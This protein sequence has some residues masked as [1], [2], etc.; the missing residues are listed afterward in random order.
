[1][2]LHKMSL[3]NAGYQELKPCDGYPVK[4]T[5][6]VVRPST[7]NQ[8]HVQLIMHVIASENERQM[9]VGE[10]AHGQAAANVNCGN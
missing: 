1:M 4:V 7:Q 2:S 8:L 9:A 10:P 6:G 5:A 3:H